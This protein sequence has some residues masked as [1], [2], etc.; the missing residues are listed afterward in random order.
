MYRAT[1]SHNGKSL[2]AISLPPATV[3]MNAFLKTP[4]KVRFLL[5][6]AV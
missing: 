6:A 2:G 4:L 3:A 1:K 5:K